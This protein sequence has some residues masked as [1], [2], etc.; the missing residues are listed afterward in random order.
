MTV[1]RCGGARR[2]FLYFS[3][4]YYNAS[5]DTQPFDDAWVDAVQT[6]L[7]T[8]TCV[9]RDPLSCCRGRGCCTSGAQESAGFYCL[10]DVAVCRVVARLGVGL[11]WLSLFLSS[12][13]PSPSSSSFLLS[14]LLLLLLFCILL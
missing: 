6:V 2:S 1:R 14:L 3:S 9:L 10:H 11:I 5:H 12:S 13:S 4:S 8:M 7:E